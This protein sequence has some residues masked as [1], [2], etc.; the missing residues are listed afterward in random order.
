MKKQLLLGSLLIASLSAIPQ[1][2][3]RV[4]KPSG[5]V[6]TKQIAKVKFA[7]E[8][9]ATPKMATAAPLAEPLTEVQGKSA[10]VTNSWIV[11]ASSM[12]IYGVIIPY[13]KPLQYNDELDAISFIHRKS[14]TY[15]IDPA[16][17]QT[18]ESGGIVAAISAD[19]GETWDS[20]AIWTNDTYWA[21]YP[22]G[23]IYNPPGNTDM[24][25]AYIVGAGPATGAGGVTWH[26]NWYASKQ[27]GFLNYNNSPDQTPNAMQA[28]PVA[29][30]PVG[31]HDFTMYS[32][33]ATDDGKM[34]VLAGITDD[35]V[36]SDSAIM[37]LTGTF[38]ATTNTFD[39][40]GTAFV[41]P[42][43]S[44]SDGSRNL[45]SR[46]LMAWNESGTVGY[47]VVMGGRLGAT[48]SNVG[49]QPIV[50]KTT[51]SGAT[52]SLE[53]SIDF[54]LPQYDDVLYPLNPVVSDSTLEVPFFNWLEGMDATVDANNKLHIFTTIIPTARN[55][56]DSIF[57]IYS[58][59]VNEYRW[60]HV[61]GARP[62]LYDFT[63]DG[64]ST[65]P[66]W[67]HMVIDTMYTEGPAGLSTGGG[68]GD[69]PWDID[70][71]NNQKVRID[72]RMHMTRSPDGKYIVYTWAESDTNV[73]TGQR[74]WNTF[75]NVKAKLL[76]VT[77]STTTLHQN[78]INITDQPGVPGDV[79]SRAWYHNTAP[80]C[81]ISSSVTANGLPVLRVPI[82]V[83][84]SNPLSQLTQN[85]HWF[86]F[87]YLNFGNIP[88]SDIKACGPVIDTSEID[89][90]SITEQM[91]SIINSVIFPNPTNGN[92]VLHI[93]AS[94]S[95]AVYI[96]VYNAVGQVVSETKMPTTAG[97]NNFQINVEGLSSGVYFVN[98]KLDGAS[99]T[100]K[101]L[102]D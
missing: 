17:A 99:G 50:Y 94:K 28:M 37:M 57:Y 82:T 23:A 5:F 64:T 68:Y 90:T 51:N 63:Y 42:V 54:N 39:W 67:S 29:S 87:N 74:N 45:I 46:P 34:R 32:F 83:S 62:Y 8:S 18:A 44:A 38:N 52:W 84:N 59:G 4:T 95:S 10:A 79:K 86:S 66:T 89:T 14:P 78:V 65:N 9:M 20:T 80:K 96:S 41:P 30:N 76:T 98:I 3:R 21:R 11:I 22:S 40:A 19:C 60:P 12:N 27:L 24:S 75:P 72:A 15:I 77:P 93:Y 49:A 85:K 6:D 58:F 97:T 7:S 33:T 25:N 26:G 31:R 53:N 102:I 55:H 73:T 35:N 16:P 47:V 88:D 100:K 71:S 91:N 48:L 36:A 1:Q 43:T 101:L 2:N 69:N 61:P 56:P 70:P 92:S 81:R 13:A